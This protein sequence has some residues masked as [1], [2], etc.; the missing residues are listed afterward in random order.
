MAPSS[1]LGP[2]LAL[3]A[4]NLQDASHEELVSH[5]GELQAAVRALQKGPVLSKEQL[6]AKVEQAQSIAARG[7]SKVISRWVPTAKQGRAKCAS[8]ELS[9]TSRG[10]NCSARSC[11]ADPR[12]VLRGRARQRDHLRRDVPSAGRQ[13]EQGDEGSQAHRSRVPRGSRRDCHWLRPLRDSARHGHARALPLRRRARLIRQV[14]LNWDADALEYKV[15]CLFL[16][17]PLTRQLSGTYGI[18]S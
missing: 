18:P 17:H 9:A 8:S 15:C 14:T 12:R 13:Q 10:R 3:S 5:I 6:D 1:D 4:S 2:L 11:G 16:D 7:I